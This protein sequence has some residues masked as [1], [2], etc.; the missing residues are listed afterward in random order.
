MPGCNGIECIEG[1]YSGVVVALY[2]GIMKNWQSLKQAE[3]DTE[4]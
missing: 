2:M 3:V 4:T 1:H